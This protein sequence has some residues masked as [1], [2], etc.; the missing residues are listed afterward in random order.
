MS[1]TGPIASP[2][3]HHLIRRAA[4]VLSVVVGG[5]VGVSMADLDAAVVRAVLVG[6]LAAALVASS[7]VFVHHRH[8]RR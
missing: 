6:V 2:S 1:A 7:T 5:I 8:L 4:W 3:P